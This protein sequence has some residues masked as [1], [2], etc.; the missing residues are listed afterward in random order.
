[1]FETEMSNT[2]IHR[3]LSRLIKTYKVVTSLF[4]NPPEAPLSKAVW[5]A[6]VC[7]DGRTGLQW[8]CWIG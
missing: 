3:R 5:L 8:M 6:S 1:L 2:C 4:A 7:H